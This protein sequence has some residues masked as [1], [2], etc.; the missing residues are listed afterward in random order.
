MLQNMDTRLGNVETRLDD[1]TTRLLRLT[2]DPPSLEDL[3][4]EGYG[5]SEENEAPR[6][7]PPDTKPVTE[8]L[9]SAQIHEQYGARSEKDEVYAMPIT[10]ERRAPIFFVV[11]A[12]LARSKFTV[13][14][15]C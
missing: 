13:A 7:L 10:K 5:I 8:A 3:M 11:I 1:L 15:H 14:N 6:P 2:K 9:T 4:C 12:N